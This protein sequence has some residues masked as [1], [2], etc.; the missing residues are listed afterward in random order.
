MLQVYAIDIDT[1]CSQIPKLKGKNRAIKVICYFSAGSFEI[2]RWA[3]L[4]AVQA[5]MPRVGGREQ[6]CFMTS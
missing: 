4:K 2:G 5:R 1:A 6:H 3:W